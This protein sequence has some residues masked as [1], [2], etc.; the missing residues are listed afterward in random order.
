MFGCCDLSVYQ[1]YPL[2]WP[3]GFYGTLPVFMNTWSP[4]KLPLVPRRIV[5]WCIPVKENFHNIMSRPWRRN[6]YDKLH[7]WSLVIEPLPFPPSY[8]WDMI[9]QKVSMMICY[10]IFF[11]G[12]IKFSLTLSWNYGETYV[13]S[14][15]LYSIIS[16]CWYQMEVMLIV[17][18]GGGLFVV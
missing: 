12:E 5:P 4:W 14:E 10:A 18:Y 8:T 11:I 7:L 13:K 17:N 3:R 16:T 15:F 6:L 9:C 1:V 2:L